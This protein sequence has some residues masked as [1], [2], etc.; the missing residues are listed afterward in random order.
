MTNEPSGRN[1]E[2]EVV[3]AIGEEGKALVIGPPPAPITYDDLLRVFEA[4]YP[5]DVAA[6]L[7]ADLTPP[8]PGAFWTSDILLGVAQLSAAH[9]NRIRGYLGWTAE[10][11]AAEIARLRST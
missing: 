2:Y 4:E 9:E 7:A 6:E 10:K 5:P 11:M 3:E 1:P 8:Q